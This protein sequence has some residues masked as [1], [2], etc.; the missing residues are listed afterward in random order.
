M[1]RQRKRKQKSQA[2]QTQPFEN[3][4]ESGAAVFYGQVC[5]SIAN[6]GTEPPTTGEGQTPGRVRIKRREMFRPSPL[7]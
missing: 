6:R 7:T 3:L 2:L 1:A 4:L 5:W